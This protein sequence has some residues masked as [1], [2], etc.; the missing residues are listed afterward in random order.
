MSAPL[1]N[2][3]AADSGRPDPVDVFRERA[4][5]RSWLVRFGVLDLRD[6][7]DGLQADAERDGLVDL[8]GQDCVQ[9]ILAAAFAESRP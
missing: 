2:Q 3:A 6:A 8:I 7:I 9:E 4:S 1:S 5:A